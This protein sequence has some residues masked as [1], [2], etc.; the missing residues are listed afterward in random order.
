MEIPLLLQGFLS[1]EMRREIE[2]I[3]IKIVGE[4]L[5]QAADMIQRA[6]TR[7][8]VTADAVQALREE[9]QELKRMLARILPSDSTG[10]NGNG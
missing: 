1:P 10:G 7:T 9:M 3:D 5:K 8:Q 6:D 2:A 4:K